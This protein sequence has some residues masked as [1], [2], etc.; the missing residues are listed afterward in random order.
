MSRIFMVCDCSVKI[1]NAKNAVDGHKYL[2]N[3]LRLPCE[4]QFVQKAWSYG[5]ISVETG[6]SSLKYQSV[7]KKY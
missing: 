6:P 1:M 3:A 5:L 2:P 4:L 7:E